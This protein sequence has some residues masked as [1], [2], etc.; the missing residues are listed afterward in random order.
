MN[1]KIGLQLQ[2]NHGLYKWFDCKCI[3]GRKEIQV[4]RTAQAP[5]AYDL[6]SPPKDRV[7]YGSLTE[8]SS[9]TKPNHLHEALFGLSLFKKH[10]QKQ[11]GHYV[12]S[13]VIISQYMHDRIVT[14]ESKFAAGPQT[15][16]PIA[17]AATQ[18]TPVALSI[19]STACGAGL[20]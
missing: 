20:S 13:K 7:S 18:T 14:V 12:C 5:G 3:L 19:A 8:G 6:G 11:T 15:V 17:S 10:L 2:I 16:L 4:C 9:G 1:A